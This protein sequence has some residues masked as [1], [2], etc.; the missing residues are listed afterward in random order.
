M[1]TLKGPYK[2]FYFSEIVLS[3]LI[4]L[5]SWFNINVLSKAVVI[6]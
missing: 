2:M 1:F 4:F 6:K 3:G 5:D